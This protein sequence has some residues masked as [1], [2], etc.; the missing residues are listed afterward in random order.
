MPDHSELYDSE[1]YRR[2]LEAILRQAIDDYIKLQHPKFRTKK[3]LEEAFES[4]VD[5]FFDSEYRILNVKNESGEDMSLQ[6]LVQEM[7]ESDKD[8]IEKIKNYVIQE[9]KTYWETKL[10]QT[11]EIP[12]T[13]IF[14]GHV[15]TV[16][17]SEDEAEVDYDEKII[18]CDRS[19]SSE[20]QERFCQLLTEIVAYHEDLVVSQKALERLGKGVFR[21]LRMN[22]C[23]TGD[24]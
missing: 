1:D 23:F 7:M 4:A 8:Q 15:Y 19:G 17:H 10:I 22:S 12:N 16:F 5:L 18:F 11:I 3:Y 13:I 20:A 2:L 21:M 9:A 14:D 24:T 6:D